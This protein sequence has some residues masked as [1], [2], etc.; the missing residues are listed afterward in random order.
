MASEIIN[1]TTLTLKGVE[2]TVTYETYE[3]ELQ[4][5]IEVNVTQGGKQINILPFIE[6]MECDIIYNEI[7]RLIVDNP[8][9][10]AYNSDSRAYNDYINNDIN[11]DL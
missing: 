3:A 2:F 4:H 9:Q 8:Y 5:L 1:E 7:D 10:Y 11:D 6:A